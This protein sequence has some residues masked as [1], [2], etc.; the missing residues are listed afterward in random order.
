MTLRVVAAA[1]IEPVERRTSTSE[2]YAPTVIEE[3]RDFFV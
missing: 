3:A 1:K 2:A